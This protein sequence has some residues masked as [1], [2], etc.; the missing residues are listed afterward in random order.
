MSSDKKMQFVLFETRLDSEPFIK[1]W[2]QFNRSSESNKG[3]ILQQSEKDG[4]FKYISQHSIIPGELEFVFT[5]DSRSSR[6]VQVQIKT[7]HA[8]GY[9]ML[10]TERHDHATPGEKK[11]FIFI[12]DPTTDLQPYKELPV[13]SQL[14]IYEAY[15]EN[16]KH[17]YILEY[18][19]K[20]KDVPALDEQLQTIEAA[21][22]HVFEECVL[23]QKSNSRKEK[24]AHVWPTI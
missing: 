7:S 21:E 24:G 5:K 3:V 19:V 20:A 14:N 22:Y 10:Q 15:Y 1:R 6:V 4:M 12:N 9:S 17:A 11:I 18:F 8:G 13:A 16:C 23:A 2:E